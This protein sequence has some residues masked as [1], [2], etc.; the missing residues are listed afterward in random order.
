MLLTH[1]PD[2]VNDGPKELPL[3]REFGLE[4]LPKTPSSSSRTVIQAVSRLR[5]TAVSGEA[6]A[7]DMRSQAST[8]LAPAKITPD[9]MIAPG[10]SSVSLTRRR[11]HPFW[12]SAS[13]PRSHSSSAAMTN[14]AR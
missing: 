2:T 9:R 11:C 5:Q 12:R 14:S 7:T 4:R 1:S 10:T 13:V 8:T 3:I 6:T